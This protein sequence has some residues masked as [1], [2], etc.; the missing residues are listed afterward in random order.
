MADEPR[1]W[2]SASDARCA[3]C[4][5]NPVGPGGIICPEC[6]TAV[7]ARNRALPGAEPGL[8][9]APGRADEYRARYRME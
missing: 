1:R 6:R 3:Q 9:S 7:E 5:I 8:A 4:H 2:Q